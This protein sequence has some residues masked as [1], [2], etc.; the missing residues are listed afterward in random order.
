MPRQLFVNIAL[1]SRVSVGVDQAEQ[2]GAE[3]KCGGIADTPRRA[4]DRWRPWRAGGLFSTGLQ[5]I[6][7]G[8]LSHVVTYASLVRDHLSLSLCL[9][10]FMSET[11]MTLVPMQKMRTSCVLFCVIA[12]T[13]LAELNRNGKYDIKMKA[14]L[15]YKPRKTVFFN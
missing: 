8:M 11:R 1:T 10:A 9:S 5:W 4:A 14:R 15:G 3:C 7:C 13:Y 2:H 6:K 12:H